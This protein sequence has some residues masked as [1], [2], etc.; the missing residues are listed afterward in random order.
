MWSMHAP[1]ECSIEKSKEKK[2]AGAT[3]TATAIEGAT[4]K[5][6]TLQPNNSLQHALTALTKMFPDGNSGSA[7]T[8]ADAYGLDF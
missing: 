6:P 1:N 3:K 4:K 8:G 5:I 7:D 2:P